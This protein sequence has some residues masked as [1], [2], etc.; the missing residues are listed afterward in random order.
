[1]VTLFQTRNPLF[2]FLF[3]LQTSNLHPL[4]Q[5]PHKHNALSVQFIEDNS[6]NIL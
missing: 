6:E 2:L 5:N 4:H 3:D 1:M